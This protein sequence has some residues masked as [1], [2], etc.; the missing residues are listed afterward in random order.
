MSIQPSQVTSRANSD[1][2]R[3]RVFLEDTGTPSAA[4]MAAIFR[5]AEEF[6]LA[7]Q[8]STHDPLRAESR[9]LR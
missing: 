8:G 1:L 6:R 4:R 9:Q 5:I 3:V 7:V 2:C